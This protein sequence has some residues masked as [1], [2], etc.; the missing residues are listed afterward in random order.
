MEV[1][2]MQVIIS[3]VIKLIVMC[4]VYVCIMYVMYLLQIMNILCKYEYIKSIS[5]HEEI[6]EQLKVVINEAAKT[7]QSL[8]IQAPPLVMDCSISEDRVTKRSTL[9]YSYKGESARTGECVSIASIRKD[10]LAH[11][12][13]SQRNI[14]PMKRLQNVW[15]GRKKKP[16]IIIIVWIIINIII[17]IN[18]QF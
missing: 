4:T 14:Q 9:F 2:A 13:H 5:D 15:L 11:G 16:F 3:R 1:S 7:I 6:G 18:L 8:L 10:V 17:I 12:V